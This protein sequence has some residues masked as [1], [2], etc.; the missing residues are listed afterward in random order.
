MTKQIIVEELIEA[1][2]FRMPTW[3]FLPFTILHLEAKN[4]KSSNIA[5]ESIAGDMVLFLLRTDYSTKH[6][7]DYIQNTEEMENLSESGKREM[8]EHF[9]Y[10]LRDEEGLLLW[11]QQRIAIALGIMQVEAR[12]LNLNLTEHNIDLSA[13]KELNQIYGLSPRYLFEIN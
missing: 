6:A 11:K 3:G 2:R 8:I 7:L 5:V 4:I 12:K 10:K 9:L 1:I 13:V